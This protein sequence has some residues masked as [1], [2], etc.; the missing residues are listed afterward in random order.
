MLYRKKINPRSDQSEED[1]GIIDFEYVF[2]MMT[3]RLGYTRKEAGHAYLG[4][5]ADMMD[6]YKTVY[7]FEKQNLLFVK[8][9]VH[10]PEETASIAD[11]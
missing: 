6:V 7:N 8:D 11:L 3:C 5:F 2:F 10:E 1:D 9:K 4:E